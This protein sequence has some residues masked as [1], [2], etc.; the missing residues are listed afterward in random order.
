MTYLP[1]GPSKTMKTKKLSNPPRQRA[2]L[3]VD[4]THAE[5][6]EQF[7]QLARSQGRTGSGLARLLITRELKNTKETK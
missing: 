7:R 5:K 1:C 3:Q 4:L 2:I 6:L